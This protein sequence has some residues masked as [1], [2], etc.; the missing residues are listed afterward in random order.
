MADYGIKKYGVEFD[1]EVDFEAG[2]FFFNPEETPD[3]WTPMAAWIYNHDY[4]C[5]GSQKAVSYL[6]MP[7]TKGFDHR[8]KD[9]AQYMRM[10]PVLDPEERE[11]R[12]K[13]YRERI[14]PFI[15]DIDKFW[16]EGGYKEKL[17]GA[18]ERIESVDMKELDDRGLIK[19]F[20]D[21]IEPTNR[22]SGELHFIFGYPFFDIPYLFYQECKKYCI[23]MYDP[24]AISLLQGI[25]NNKFVNLI[26]EQWRLSRRAIELGVDE[27]ISTNQPQDVISKLE[28]NGA[29]REWLEELKEFIQ[30]WYFMRLNQHEVINPTWQEDPTTVIT[31]IARSLELSEDENPE[32]K[33]K[34][35]VEKREKAEKE[36]LARIPVEDK[37]YMTVL[38]KAAQKCNRWSDDHAI[39]FEMRDWAIIRLWALEVGRRLVERG[40][41]DSPDDTLFMIPEE[42]TRRFFGPE[43]HDWR[44]LVIKRRQAWEENRKKARGESEPFLPVLAAPGVNIE[45]MAK[46]MQMDEIIRVHGGPWEQPTHPEMEADLHGQPG[47]PGMGEGPAR[48][49]FTVAELAEVQKGEIMVCPTLPSTWSM[50][51]P[52]LNGL[53]LEG[54]GLLSHGAILGR[55]YGLPVCQAISEATRKVK[56]GQIVKVDGTNGLVFFLDK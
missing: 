21:E 39:D 25:G 46:T 34:A 5:G 1:P 12:R 35:Q 47:A 9:G 40:F 8:V 54:T 27:V 31:N 33:E 6:H 38:M 30:R 49:V 53:I 50:V 42:I 41:L 19:L 14:R 4:I 10:I 44:S 3:A 45:E 51:F 16:E 2:P 56:S 52:L 15:E 28:E 7:N 20:E 43:I 13:V 48:V 32:L 22:L 18:Y 26:K 23:D 36:F 55:E 17:L 37:E 29:G 24:V 11:E